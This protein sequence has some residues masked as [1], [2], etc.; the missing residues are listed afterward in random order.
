MQFVTPKLMS[1]AANKDMFHEQ[2]SKK[3]QGESSSTRQE[4]A[5]HHHECV[6]A[7]IHHN[8]KTT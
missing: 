4:V 5:S 2:T 1:A 6:A 3:W 8:T 7:R